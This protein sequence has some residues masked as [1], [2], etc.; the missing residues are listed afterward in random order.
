MLYGVIKL[1]GQALF[2]TKQPIYS[3]NPALESIS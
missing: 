2:L 1:R 3:I